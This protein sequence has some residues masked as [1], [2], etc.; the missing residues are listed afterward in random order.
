MQPYLRTIDA[1]GALECADSGIHTLIGQIAIAALAVG[2]KGQHGVALLVGLG[3]LE[4][5]SGAQWIA[6][7]PWIRWHGSLWPAANGRFHSQRNAVAQ[8]R[9]TNNRSGVQAGGT[10]QR[11]QQIGC[12]VEDPGVVLEVR[13]RVQRSVQLKNLHHFVEAPK[14][15]LCR[16]QQ[17]GAR[18]PCKHIAVFG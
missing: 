11:D 7:E 4:S 1:E 10:K 18:R 8:G 16:G 3:R 12:A 13:R 14:R 17:I 15:S 5:L 6:K 9:H 2:T